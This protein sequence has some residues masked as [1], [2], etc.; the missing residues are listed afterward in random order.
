MALY[1]YLCIT[2]Y[3]Y[4]S[5]TRM[6][7]SLL[8]NSATARSYRRRHENWNDKKRRMFERRSADLADDLEGWIRWIRELVRQNVKIV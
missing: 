5:T 2:L 6:V 7:K 8:K 1:D 4:L 3:D